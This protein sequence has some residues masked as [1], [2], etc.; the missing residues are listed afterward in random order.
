M[1]RHV[2]LYRLKQ[3]KEEDKAELKARFLSMQGQV[4][5]IRQLEVGTD[6]L[7]SPRSFDVS[8]SI[9]FDCKEDLAAYKAHPFHKSVSAYVHSVI[10]DSVS[11]D[12]EV[13][14]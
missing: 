14:L 5:Q 8:L 10:A 3:R 11:C 13:D 6:T 4:P 2:V 12:Y 7:N 1:F 9:L